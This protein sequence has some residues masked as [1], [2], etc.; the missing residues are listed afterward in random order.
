MSARM[1]SKTARLIASSDISTPVSTAFCA[2]FA[3]AS[4]ASFAV[5]GHIPSRAAVISSFGVG[6]QSLRAQEGPLASFLTSISVSP[7]AAK[8]S[9]QAAST[10]LGSLA[11][12]A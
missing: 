4:L 10:A 9:R 3:P 5:L 6:G 11:N 2:I 8:K 7:R 1:L 12:C